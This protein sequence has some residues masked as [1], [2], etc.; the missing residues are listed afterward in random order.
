M[1]PPGPREAR[2]KAKRHRVGGEPHHYGNRARRPLRGDD[3]WVILRD[4]DINF[5]SH[6]FG[7]EF[8]EPFWSSI[9]VAH[10]QGDILPFHVTKL[11][12][13]MT[14]YL[15]ERGILCSRERCEKPDPI[16]LSRLGLGGE[17][18]DDNA[19]EPCEE[20]SAV[21]DTSTERWR[22]RESRLGPL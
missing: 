4:D 3:S 11:P 15:K 17:R 8:R 9:G 20:G 13:S 18:R 5:E 12:K 2:D 6:E 21:H 14:E 22:A 19:G 16:H 10:L 7:G 1:L